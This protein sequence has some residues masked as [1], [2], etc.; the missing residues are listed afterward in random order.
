MAWD[1]TKVTMVEKKKKGW[2]RKIS[3]A[4]EHEL[5]LKL[6]EIAMATKEE[7]EKGER[8]I[9]FIKEHVWDRTKIFLSC[10]GA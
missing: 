5:E 8:K 3:F 2:E 4:I 6:F 9:G 10:H 7:E 1:R